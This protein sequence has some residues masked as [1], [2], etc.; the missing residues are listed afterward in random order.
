MQRSSC[1]KRPGNSSLLAAIL[2]A[3]FACCSLHAAAPAPK[4]QL[5]WKDNSDNEDGFTIERAVAAAGQELAFEEI[6]SVPADS[7][8]YTDTSIQYGQ[9]YAYRVK[10]FNEFGN[11][12]FTNV[13]YGLAQDFTPRG[14]PSVLLVVFTAPNGQTYT[15]DFKDSGEPYLV[16]L[17]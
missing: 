9:L 6:D 2:L 5:T 13:S 7:T 11:S 15:V 8:S 3:F 14:A 10:A 12:G 4:V 1:Q 17:P 16:E